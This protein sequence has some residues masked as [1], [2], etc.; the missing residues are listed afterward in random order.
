MDE[1]ITMYLIHY[2]F[3]SLALASLYCH[4]DLELQ[5]GLPT[6][7]NVRFHRSHGGIS[8][9]NRQIGATDREPHLHLPP[10]A[11]ARSQ[12]QLLSHQG[13]VWDSYVITTG[14]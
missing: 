2:D 4:P 3:P 12:P 11:T 9:G 13:L 10:I 8:D 6:A 14:W 5:T 7:A 1:S